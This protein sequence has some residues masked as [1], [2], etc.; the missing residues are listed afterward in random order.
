MCEMLE[1]NEKSRAFDDYDVN[2][3]DENEQNKWLYTLSAPRVEEDIVATITSEETTGD[4]F[5]KADVA[6]RIIVRASALAWS[7]QGTNLGIGYSRL[8]T[9]GW[10]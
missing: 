2:W 9:S 5:D 8:D 6:K 3:D 1:K 4:F 10:D 7:A